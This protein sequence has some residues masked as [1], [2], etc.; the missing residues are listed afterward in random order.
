MSVDQ[1]RGVQLRI[2]FTQDDIKAIERVVEKFGWRAD[3]TGILNHILN[4]YKMV[5][6]DDE[7]L[8]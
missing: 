5:T 7:D 8:V 6:G 4:E 2:T 3:E 1:A